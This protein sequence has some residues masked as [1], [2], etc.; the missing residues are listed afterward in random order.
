[1]R[2]VGVYGGFSGAGQDDTVFSVARLPLEISDW[3]R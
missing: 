3:A 1:M 2:S